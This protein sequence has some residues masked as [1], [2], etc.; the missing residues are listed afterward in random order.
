MTIE[1]ILIIEL[2]GLVIFYFYLIKGL[3]YFLFLSAVLVNNYRI[4]ERF[5]KNRRLVLVIPLPI[6]KGD[7]IFLFF[8]GCFSK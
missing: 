1:K 8:E 7:I 4:V 3:I 5:L 6:H 2:V